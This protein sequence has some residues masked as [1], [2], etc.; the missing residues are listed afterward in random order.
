MPSEEIVHDRT[1]LDDP[2]PAILDHRG[3]AERIDREELW[4][5]EPRLG[6][7]LVAPDLVGKL[8][9]LQQPEDA[10]RAR[11]VQVVKDNHSTPPM[12]FRTASP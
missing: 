12:G 4:R 6:V 7:A 3:L 2:L 10:L 1:G 8:E 9:L 11:V 5:R